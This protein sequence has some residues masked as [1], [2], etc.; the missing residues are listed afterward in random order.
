MHTL[1]KIIRLQWKIT[2]RG[3]SATTSSTLTRQKAN[4]KIMKS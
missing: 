1:K 4:P 3:T 2:R